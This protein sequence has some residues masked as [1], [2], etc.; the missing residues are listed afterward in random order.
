MIIITV[1]NTMC[2][3]EHFE[4][5]ISEYKSVYTHHKPFILS[6]K[7]RSLIV[8]TINSRSYDSTHI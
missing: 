5:I 4:I 8:I 1:M 6:Q 3:K 2:R 7:H